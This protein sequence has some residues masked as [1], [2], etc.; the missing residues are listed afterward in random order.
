MYK[1]IEHKPLTLKSLTD[2]SVLHFADCPSVSFVEGTPITYKQLGQK[3]EEVAALLSSFGL[4]KGDKVALF[5]HNMPNWV[6]A[7][8]SVVSKGMIPIKYRSFSRKFLL[9]L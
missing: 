7:Y 6:I 4:Q 5:S 1:K 9:T 8:F 2:Y 3:I